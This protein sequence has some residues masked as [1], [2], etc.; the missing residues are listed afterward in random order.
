MKTQI[1]E[2]AAEVLYN[3]TRLVKSLPA[4]RLLSA[5]DQELVYLTSWLPLFLTGCS[6][7]LSLAE[8]EVV[9]SQSSLPSSLLSLLLTSVK[10]LQSPG[11]SP[12]QLSYLRNALIF[13]PRPL[14]SPKLEASRETME[15]M[16]QHALSAAQ[17]A[18]GPLRLAE[19]IQNVNTLSA[20]LSADFV[21]K[22]FFKDVIEDVNMDLIVMDMF[23]NNI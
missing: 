22:L 9:A 5:S 13:L 18:I 12:L 14:L 15:V 6:S 11:L 21:H 19:I 2:A 1:S 16:G 7:R 10:V 3:N 8:V 17:L 4:F 23:R 20:S